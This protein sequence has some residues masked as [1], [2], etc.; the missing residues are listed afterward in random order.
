V[1]RL[2]SFTS[3]EVNA[4]PALY[5]KGHRTI[6]FSDFRGPCAK[7]FPENGA[8]ATDKLQ[9]KLDLAGR[10]LDSVVFA[11]LDS[12]KANLDC[13][14]SGATSLKRYLWRERNAAT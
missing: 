6:S 12:S 9:L 11:V 14:L 7:R 3:I 2:K 8:F 4:M 10:V 5:I 13:A 1:T